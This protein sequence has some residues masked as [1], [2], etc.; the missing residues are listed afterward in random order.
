[1]LSGGVFFLPERNNSQDMDPEE[2]MWEII[3]PSRF[4]TT[5]AVAQKII[6]NDPTLEL[7]DVRS[8]DAFESY[9]LPGAINIPL[10]SIMIDEYQDYLGI[11]DMN[12]VFYSNDDLKAE[13]AWLIARRIGYSSIYVM[14]GGLNCWINTIIQPKS[15]EESASKE[16]F[17]LYN[18]RK[19]ASMYFTGAQIDSPNTEGKSTINVI[20]KK[21][22]AVAEGGC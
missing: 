8:V 6:I 3:Q 14:Q 22:K 19:G 20:R 13:Q 7:I 2:L 17:E 9:A 11:E 15:P 16:E 1:M 4:V 18:L 21:K 5:D 12:V 10:D